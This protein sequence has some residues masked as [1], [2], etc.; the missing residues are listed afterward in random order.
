MRDSDFPSAGV[1][2]GQGAVQDHGAAPAFASP[3]NNLCWAGEETQRFL[4]DKYMSH[5]VA[6]PLAT[7]ETG[8][9]E[10]LRSR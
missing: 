3:K 4:E 5:T 10:G 8:E 6:F 1:A 9:A 7:G 2:G